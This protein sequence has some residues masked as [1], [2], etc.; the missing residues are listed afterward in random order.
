MRASASIAQACYGSS[1]KFWTYCIDALLTRS[2]YPRGGTFV[3]GG[4]LFRRVVA[5]YAAYAF[6]WSFWSFLA[7]AV[8][9]TEV[10]KA[11]DNLCVLFVFVLFG[12]CYARKR[13]RCSLMFFCFDSRH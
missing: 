8:A 6:D 9:L 11:K 3:A 7:Q 2:Q 13:G 12:E 5:A 1:Y 4:A 10:S